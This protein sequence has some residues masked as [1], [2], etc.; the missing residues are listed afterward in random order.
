[1]ATSLCFFPSFFF[2]SFALFFFFSLS[3]LLL[4]FSCSVLSVTFV[5]GVFVS[6]LFSVVSISPLT[7]P[8]FLSSF[9]FPSILPSPSSFSSCF[10]SSFLFCSISVPSFNP[11]V[12]FSFSFFTSPPVGLF[13]STV[14]S[15]L[16]FRSIILFAFNLFHLFRCFFAAFK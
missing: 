9:W 16:L 6:S 12:S 2:F 14:S 3:F 13:F 10:S 11:P 1:M 8:S 4:F 5:T 7:S 15:F